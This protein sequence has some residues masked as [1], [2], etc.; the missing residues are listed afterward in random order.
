MLFLTALAVIYAHLAYRSSVTSAAQARAAE[1]TSL[2]I[3]ANAALDEA[4]RAMLAVRSACQ[5]NDGEWSNHLSRQ[6]MVLLA[7]HAMFPERKS[8]PV[9]RQGQILLAQLQD[10][11]AKDEAKTPPD[12]EALI[13]QARAVASEI[14][15]LTSQLESP[16]ENPGG[17]R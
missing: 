10:A 13:K 4:G 16:P 15:G 2:K 17:R 7:A 11:F 5:A 3:Q 9:E 12:Y 6:P 8:A 14:V 1:L